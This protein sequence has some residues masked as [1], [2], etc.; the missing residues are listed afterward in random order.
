MR[1]II[2]RQVKEAEGRPRVIK[3]NVIKKFQTERQIFRENSKKGVIMIDVIKE[4]IE[5]VK[6]FGTLKSPVEVYIFTAG[7]LFVGYGIG[8]IFG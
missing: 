3:R 8:S 7:V 5:L 6:E 1:G 2:D 4:T